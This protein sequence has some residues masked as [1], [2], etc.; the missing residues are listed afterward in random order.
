VAAA[1][2]GTAAVAVVVVV[3]AAVATAAGTVAVAGAE[4]IAAVDVVATGSLTP[5]AGD[6]WALEG[7]RE[8]E[9]VILTVASVTEAWVKFTN[10]TVIQTAILIDRT[11]TWRLVRRP[12]SQRENAGQALCI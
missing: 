6:E 7:V 11:K 2:A 9:G 12:R 4:M 5:R 10:G 8:L 1:A 3:T